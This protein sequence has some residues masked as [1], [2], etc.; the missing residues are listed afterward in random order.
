MQI[1]GTVIFDGAGFWPKFDG[2]GDG[3][4]DGD[5]DDEQRQRRRRRLRRRKLDLVAVVDSVKFSSKSELSSRFFGRLKFS[6]V[7]AA[8]VQR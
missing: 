2:D 3:D 8:C 6:D 7:F 1:K 4:S 5:G